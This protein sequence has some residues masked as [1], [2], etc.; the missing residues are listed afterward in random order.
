[1][2]KFFVMAMA[3]IAAVC[4]SAQKPEIFSSDGV[5]IRGYDPVAYFTD[6]KPVKGS[7]SF[8]YSWKG[9]D[10]YFASKKNFD[11]F[12]ANPE[13]YA[14]QYGGWCAYGMARGYKA[15]T[16]ADAWSIV[17]GKLYLNYDLDVRK[18]WDKD[19]PGYIS[20]ANKNWPTVRNE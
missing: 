5:A 17:D 4:V 18:T 8:K 6:H 2:K 16:E 19:R 1:M 3:M 11:M 10:W 9:A 14:P 20:K 7:A 13:K 15:R 12:K